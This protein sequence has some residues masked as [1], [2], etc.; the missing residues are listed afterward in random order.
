MDPNDP[1]AT[2]WN[3]RQFLVRLAVTGVA[4]TSVAALFT[5]PPA[6]RAQT[7]ATTDTINAI[8]AF[9]VPGDDPYSRQQGMATDRPG[10][11]TPGTTDSLRRTFDL[12]VPDMGLTPLGLD[13]TGADAVAALVNLFAVTA[14]PS[15]VTGP[16][17]APF[18]N[19]SH[20]SK[21]HVFDLLDTDPRFPGRSIAYAVNA[22]PTLAAFVAYSEVSA[23]DRDRRV[24][25]GRP[26]GWA[27][28]DYAGVGDGWDEFL[29]YYGGVDRVEG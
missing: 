29:G 22:I 2:V 21:A 8:L 13:V 14:E 27:L 17:A 23:F 24:L 10:G 5:A 18:A 16:F 12:A 20:A 25:T 9:V 3:R 7:D 1:V 28:S 26:V 11:V 19:L 4:A 6:A 15:S